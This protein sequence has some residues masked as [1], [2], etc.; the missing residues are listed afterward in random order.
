[1]TEEKKEPIFTINR[2]DGSRKEVFESDLDEKTM[3]LAN[4][5]SSVNRSIQYKK[6]SELYQ[7]AIHLTQDLRSLERDSNNLAAQLDEA[8]ESNNKKVE[9]VK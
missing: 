3:P 4:E 7:Q 8:L 1:M 9:V 5:L 2:E 6:N